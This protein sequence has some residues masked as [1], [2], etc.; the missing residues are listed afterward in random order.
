MT[1]LRSPLGRARGLG[2]AKSGLASFLSLRIAAI[3]LIPL[4]LWF[5]VAAIRLMG[6]DHDAL[7][8]FLGQPG[9]AAAFV[10]LILAA[11][12][13]ARLGMEEVI[14]D[15]VH[16]KA[17]QISLLLGVRFLAALLA[18]FLVLAVVKL[19]FGV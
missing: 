14:V 8:E 19:G 17:A 9:N 6:A 4:C 2:S 16:A 11:F 3:A 5:V 10:L 15:Y 7:R 12:H 13:H 18:A 1:T